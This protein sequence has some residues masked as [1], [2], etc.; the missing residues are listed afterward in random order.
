MKKIS[1]SQEIIFRELY[2]KH[3]GTPMA[4]SSESYAHKQLRYEHICGIF[5]NE[6]NITIHDVGMGIADMNEYILKHYPENNIIY[7]GSD[8]LKEYVIE[9]SKRFPKHVFY[10]RDITESDCSDRYDYVIMSG[11][12]H[13]RRDASIKD[14]EKY[15]QKILLNAFAMC[16]KGI[17]FNAITPFVDFYQLD[18]YYCNLP[19]LLNFINDELSRFFLIKHNYALFEFT[20]YVYKESIILNRYPQE[21]FKKYFKVNYP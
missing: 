9:S 17:A 16:K 6:K 11:V 15:L 1:D 13:Q 2:N 5:E 10:H 21:E 7:S 14:W 19:K 8:I 20:V 3:K 18:V 4:V 12:F